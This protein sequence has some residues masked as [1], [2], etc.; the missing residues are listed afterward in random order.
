MKDFYLSLA[1]LLGRQAWPAQALEGDGQGVLEHFYI[2]A[3]QTDWSKNGIV[4]HSH[5]L[6]TAQI[7]LEIPG[8]PWLTLALSPTAGGTDLPVTITLTP[9][10]ISVHDLAVVAQVRKDILQPMRTPTEKDPTKKTTDIVLGKVTLSWGGDQSFQ[11]LAE[12]E[13]SLPLCMI[14]ESGVVIEAGKVRWLTPS[15]SAPAGATDPP[16]VGFTGLYID[17][18][19]LH[20]PDIDFLPPTVRFDD[21]YIGTGG[22]TGKV[23]FPSEMEWDAAK[24]EFKGDMVG[25]LFGFKCGLKNI[26]IA[27]V[28]SCLQRGAVVGEIFLPYFEK[29]VGIELNLNMSGDFSV[30]FAGT[31]SKNPDTGVEMQPDGLFKLRKDGLIEALLDSVAFEKHTETVS[32]RLSGQITPLFGKKQG[33]DWPTFDVK[34]LS[35]DSKGNVRLDGGWLNLREQK[36]LNFYGFQME[37]TKLGFGKTE[38]G[39]KW[40][41]FSGGV[42]LVEGVPAGASVEG[43]RI[44]WYDGR[45]QDTRISFNGVGVE[46]EVPN[47][48]KFKGAVAYREPYQLGDETV[49]RF[50]GDIKLKLIALNMEI[51]ATLVFGSASGPRGNYN[52]FA[53][54]LGVEL[55]AGIPL[56]S[57][58]LALYGMAGLFATQMEP[59]KE[60]DEGWYENPDGSDGWYKRDTVGVTDLAKKWDPNFGSLAFGVGA[61]IGTVPDNGT[62]F[63][64][65]F[66][67]VIVFPGPIVLLEGRGNLLKKR[68]VPDKPGDTKTTEEP[69]FRALAVL[70]NRAGTFTVGLD[71]QYKQLDDAELIDIHGSAEAFFSFS[72]ANAWHIY[73]GREEREYRVRARIFRGLFEANAYFMLDQAFVRTGAWV[74]FA[75]DWIFGPVGVKVEAFIDGNAALSRKPPQFHGELT[76]HGDVNVSA[77]GIGFKLL[78]DANCTADVFEPFHVVFDFHV[79][80]DLPW[81]FPDFKEDITLEWG[82][83]PVPP[84]LPLPLQEIAV[85]HLKVTTSWPLP[86]GGSQPLLMPNYDG[87]DGFLVGSPPTFNANDPAPSSVPVVPLDAR[88][89]LT[90]GRT[91]HDDAKVGVNGLPVLPDADPRGWERIGNPAE[92]QGPVR[93]RYSLQEVALEKYVG[94]S[95]PWKKIAWAPNTDGKTKLFGSWA[96]VPSTSDGGGDVDQVKLWLWSKNPFDYTRHSGRAWDEWFTSQF[97]NYP[98]VPPPSDREICCEV[99]GIDPDNLGA[100]SWRCP[101]HPEMEISWVAP[102][103]SVNPNEMTI[104]LPPG[105]KGVKITPS[106]WEIIRPCVDFRTYPIGTGPNP[107]I[108]RGV[109]FIA[110]IANFIPFPPIVRIVPAANTRIVNPSEIAP[111]L[112][113]ERQ[114]E[115]ILPRPCTAVDMLF[116]NQTGTAR[117]EAFNLDGLMAGA[118]V[119][120]PQDKLQPLR[121]RGPAITR[122]VVHSIGDTFLHQLCFAHF[123]VT[124]KGTDENGTIYLPSRDNDT[125]AVTGTDMTEV[126]VS[127]DGPVQIDKI[128]VTL[129]P[130]SAEVIRREEMN[131]HLVD[132]MARWSHEDDVLEPDTVYRLK[133]VTKLQV[134]SNQQ[135]N[136]YIKQVNQ[137][138]VYRLLPDPEQIEYAYFRTEGPPG[139]TDLS[140]PLGKAIPSTY[141][142]GTVSVTKGSSKVQGTGVNWSQELVGAAFQAKDDPVAHIIKAVDA[143]DKITL[144]S[145]YT[146]ATSTGKEYV[147]GGFESGVDDLTRY[148]RQTVPATVSPE[149]EPPLL[150]RPVYCAYDVGVEFNVNYIDLMYRMARRDLGLYLYNGN[151]QPVRDALGRLIVLSNRWGT[152]EK[153]TLTEREER[154]VKV[155][156]DST[157]AKLDEQKITPNKTLTSAAEGQVLDPDTVY[158]ARL[159]PLLLHEDFT[160][161]LA[162]WQ[163]IDQAS[164]ASKWEVMGHKRLHGENATATGTTLNLDGSPDL[165]KVALIFDTIFLENDTA[166]DTRLYRIISVDNS[167]KTVTVDTTPN[168]TGGSSK[169]HI[170]ALGAVVQ[171]TSIGGGTN[172]GKDPVKPGTMLVRGDTN[173]TDYRLSVLLRATANDDA[174]GVV[175]RQKDPNTYYRFSMDRERK[176][177]RLMKVINAAH[178]ILAEDDFVYRQNVD[179]LITVEAIGKSLRI[180]QDGALVFA[181]IDSAENAIANGR[182][183]LYC[184]NNAGVRFSDVRV[185]DFHENAPVPYRFKFTTSQFANFF[186]HLHSYQDEIWPK[187]LPATANVFDPLSK[188][189]V[190]TTSP[191]DDEARA[192]ETLAKLVLE[193]QAHQNPSELQVTRVEHNDQKKGFLIQSPEPIDWKRTELKVLHANRRVSM[194]QLPGAA[195]LTDVT[196]GKKT[197]NEESVTLLLREAMNLTGY[198]IEQR[199]LPGPLTESEP[200]A[201]F[202]D[203]F[204][205][206]DSGVLFREEFGPNALDHYVIV[207]EEAPT[208][209]R[210]S[211]WAVSDDHIVQTGNYIGGGSSEA[212]PEKPGTIA[213]T[214]LATWADVRIS[215]TLRSEDRDDIG[216]VFRYQDDQNYYRFSMSRF[217]NYRRL[218]K[219]SGGVVKVL[220]EDAVLYNLSQ[221]YHLVLETFGNR[222]LGYVD[223]ALLFSVED[224]D[225]AAGRVGLYCWRNTGAHF[226]AL[227]IE[228]LESDPVLWHPA[229]TDMSE[230]EVIDDPGAGG[231]ASNWNATGGVLT[232]SLSLIGGEDE[233]WEALPG[234]AQ[235]IAVGEDGSAWATLMAVPGLY[236]LSR[237]NGVDWDGVVSGGV[238]GVRIAVDPAGLPWVVNDARQIFRWDG[239]AFQQLPGL[240]QDIGIGPTGTPPYIVGTNAVPGGFGIYYW[241]GSSWQQLPDY[242]GV[243][244][245]VGQDGTPWVVDNAQQIFVYRWNSR[246]WQ[247]LPGAAYDIGVGADGSVWIVGTDTVPGGF[248]IYRWNGVAWEK[249]SRFGAIGISVGPDGNPWAVTDTERIFRW[250][251]NIY[252]KPGTFVLGGSLASQDLQISARLRPNG[253]GAIGVMFRYVDADNYYRFSMDRQGN[254]RRLIKKVGGKVSKLW[255][256]QFQFSI[257]NAYE[258]TI[259][260]VGERLSV[261]LDGTH[262]LTVFDKDIEHGRVGLYC[263]TNTGARFERVLVKDLTRRVGQWTIR[264]E[265]QTGEPSRWR[266][267]RGELSQ[268]SQISGGAAPNSPGT[269]V[270]GGDPNW[271]NYRLVARMRSDTDNAIGLIFRYMDDDNYYRLSVDAKIKK[272]VLMK[273]VNG[274]FT[275]IAEKP[276]SFNVSES[277]ALTVDAV[278]AQLVAYMDDER[279]FEVID[280]T[281]TTGQVGLYC[282][283]NDAAHFE[284]IEVRQPVLEASALL[285]DRFADNDV[286]GWRFVDQGAP[287]EVSQWLTIAGVLQHRIKPGLPGFIDPNKLKAIGALAL[288]RN[289][290]LT[291]LMIS[292]RLQPLDDGAIGIVF[293]YGDADHYYLFR[294]D[295]ENGRRQ[296]VKNAAG[297]ST[298]LWEDSF[299]IKI[300]HIYALVVVTEGGFLRG[301]IDNLPM[302]VVEDA[303]SLQKGQ[304]GLYCTANMK[305]QF[306]DVRVYAADRAFDNWLL[307]EPF[308][309]EGAG[310]W[311]FV[312]EAGQ[313]ISLRWQVTGGE[314]QHKPST[315]DTVWVEDSLPAGARALGDAESWNWIDTNPAPLSGALAHQSN[316][317]A[318]IHQHYFDSATDTLAIKAEDTLFAYVYLDPT[319]PPTEVMLQWNDGTWDHRAYWGTNNIGWGVDGTESRSRMGPLPVAG[320]WVRLEVPA[321]QVGLEGKIINGMAFTLFD[322][323]ATWDRAGKASRTGGTVGTHAVAGD[324][325]W[326]DY[327]FTARLAADN[328]NGAI[329][330]TFR[331]QDDKNYYRFFIDHNLGFGHLIKKIDGVESELWKGTIKYTLGREHILTIDCE[332]SRL[333]GYLNGALLFAKEDGDHVAGRIGLYCWANTWAHFAEVRVAAPL[334]VQHYTFNDEKRMPAGTRVRV[335]SGNTNAPFDKKPGVVNRFVASH[336]D[337]GRLHWPQDGVD[338]RVR[339]RGASTGHTRRFLPENAYTDVN[340]NDLR[341]LRKADGTGFF[342]TIAPANSLAAGQYRLI[343]TYRRDNQAADESSQV[344]SEAGNS[345]P[346]TVTIDIPMR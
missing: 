83:E 261:Y 214:G 276:G 36:P 16:P 94:G 256:E 166:R 326:T 22:F 310:R 155:V 188:L 274:V 245:A 126:Q 297:A 205:G 45:P 67:L 66:L 97:P 201:L 328:A 139:L 70:D 183:G 163:T 294:M 262:L 323:R 129:P 236:A 193:S 52:F 221:S 275:A 44:V 109:K 192:Y 312:D 284:K 102:N 34:E 215:A 93:A 125:I 41:G 170:P 232:Q 114:L 179:Y 300:E 327:R 167:A 17:D 226:E 315:D 101:D 1:D 99:A 50:D 206:A 86:R 71:A 55:P 260:T 329:G 200:P 198:R 340:A 212:Q 235:D 202:V 334:W 5:L 282:W 142:T 85:E 112:A 298:I 149:G 26:E 158:E 152:A 337:N 171:T 240:A 319:N 339:Q 162:G 53:I 87:G 116:T 229:F 100:S 173:W 293:C 285:R 69:L 10:T 121:L 314:L 322:G 141:N 21:C 59:N 288:A 228:S 259:R 11:I 120:V 302:F 82:P 309:I 217:G 287:V 208:M 144:T 191:T 150:P 172:D 283:A 250:I 243:R 313:P 146:G 61:T 154:W 119:P 159:V 6:I 186:H 332:G 286:S 38:D 151:N 89:H 77:F 130:D 333:T 107:R 307:D 344:F 239:N 47:V 324:Q 79:A 18:A 37:I 133:V 299:D 305:A 257:G 227:Q 246:M 48:L 301:Y 123:L 234:S 169:W 266:L 24:N 88:P 279:I 263:H 68:A 280:D 160:E 14:G 304:I 134:E 185:D 180:Y 30:T 195:K 223:D 242:G 23:S 78:V 72:D 118:P 103:A 278:G 127:S 110:H 96:P 203:D 135:L 289:L 268:I 182:I 197:P 60:P 111:A 251:G 222:L 153:L 157:C 145:D 95:K 204:S 189:V 148:V 248:R 273:K 124:A 342:L 29:R 32:I 58:G 272:R 9:F 42:K 177:R 303:Q 91:V 308:D 270:V 254:Y 131:K 54:Y 35:I 264:D 269:K 74:G 335:F 343:M 15:D 220:W 224:T 252:H 249:A 7:G 140:V 73:V 244:I 290:T 28:Q 4:L 174:M 338:L 20:L 187:P 237:W 318:G 57:T 230:L 113:C 75:K 12:A 115:I 321:K 164:P 80:V 233:A 291:D 255:E 165:S 292:V 277:F 296:L 168:L 33:L 317:A 190:P 178:I 3:L 311:T 238:G 184:W 65:K 161:D 56:W 281:H 76:L 241:D 51:D 31:Q 108:E 84:P 225:I 49:Q 306:S 330:V 105:A 156:N 331:C 27:F 199:V 63:H 216:M 90:F 210:P 196:F 117:V 219:K 265:V 92:N 143:S 39:G 19:Q 213:L 341:V 64:G 104:K 106:Q 345:D 175:F 211:A 122:I 346:E 136:G 218:I 231:V 25:E 271:T 336:G 2:S 98:C 320:Q 247:Q 40:I 295:S 209:L 258:L 325:T 46:F 138:N 43:L 267:T 132:E 62:S 194:P 13:V 316:L 147:I 81:P 253:S 181:A 176:Y 128:C 137:D 8:F 207:D